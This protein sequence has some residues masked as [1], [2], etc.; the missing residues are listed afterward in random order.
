MSIMINNKWQDQIPDELMNLLSSGQGLFET[1]LY[2]GDILWFWELHQA[3]LYKSLTLFNMAEPDF[4]LKSFLLQSINSLSVKHPLRIKLICLFPFDRPPMKVDQ[5]NFLIQISSVDEALPKKKQLTLKTMPAV[6]SDR[7][8][9]IGHKTLAYTYFSYSR[10]L[11]LESGFEDVLFYN[12]D[13]LIQET[14]YS[15]IFAVKGNQLFT[16]KCSAGILPGTV[17]L[18]LVNKLKAKEVDIPL[19]MIHNYDYFF[20]TSSIKELHAISKIDQYTF[21]LNNNQFELIKAKYQSIK[22]NYKKNNLRF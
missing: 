21:R 18:L 10:K 22:V 9:L 8:L 14:S 13:G 16:P 19:S 15:N 1:I 12:Q 20:V 5:S 2:E 7:N 4:D 17:R 3:R 11:A 6:L